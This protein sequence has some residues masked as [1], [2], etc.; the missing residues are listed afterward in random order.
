MQKVPRRLRVPLALVLASLWSSACLAGRPLTVDDANVDEP[1]AGHVEAWYARQTG[2]TPTWTVAPAY[3]PWKGVELAA[4]LTRDTAAGLTTGSVQAKFRLTPS[5]ENGCNFGATLAAS[6]T[7]GQG[8]ATPN[9]TGL[10][11]CNASA[12]SLHLNLGASRP[13]GGPTLPAFGIAWEQDLGGAT[14]H[15][16]WLAQRQSKSTLGLGLRKEVFRNFQ[17]DGSIGH[18]ADEAL[19]SLGVKLAF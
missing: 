15:I 11:S 19:F 6:H 16:E 10:M 14:G 2:D 5:V 12:G 13:P 8:S 3:S 9:A 17:I 7:R 4:A 1:G 18:N